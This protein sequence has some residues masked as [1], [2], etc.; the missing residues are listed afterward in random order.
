MGIQSMIL[1][2]I[3]GVLFL[4]VGSNG[5]CSQGSCL[6]HDI[7]AKDSDC[8]DGLKC[9]SCSSVG[10][11][12]YRCTRFN[13]T[14]PVSK[15]GGLPFNRYSWLTTHNSYAIVGE[16][17]YT[18][19]AR[20]TFYN[21][22]DSVTSQLNNGVRGLMLDMYD[23]ENDIWL[24]HSFG[25][26]CLNITAFMPAINTLKEITAFLAAN[27]SEIIT[28]FIEDY[29]K[30]SKGL[31]KVF[32]TAGLMK[33]WFPVSRMPQNGGDWPTVD[34][35]VAKNQ[36]LIVF[37]S[38]SSKEASEGI[39][40][41]WKYVV[42]NQY[43]DAGL[44]NGSCTNRAESK[45]LTS[46]SQSLFLE[47]FF[48]TNPS[49]PVACTVNSDRLSNILSVCYENAGKRWANFLAVD[50]YKKSYGGGAFQAVDKLN[51]QLTC[52][53]SDVTECQANGTF[54]VCKTSSNNK[55]NTEGSSTSVTSGQSGTDA[56]AASYVESFIPLTV[57]LFLLHLMHLAYTL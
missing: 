56:S 52:G 7:C 12:N 16:R 27:P 48:P 44:P 17:S 13:V 19:T 40:Y 53:C 3:L 42:E 55:S 38:Q 57:L 37:T 43:G 14:D 31:T 6:V 49:V 4:A 8:E 46:T 24:C 11:M 1:V 26:T 35:M 41:Q 36:R 2:S 32:T 54:G 25:G 23:F 29:V 47:N 9:L 15:V 45:N 50:Y 33:Y 30:S 28:I 10:D 39:A 5:A 22:D 21:Q 20:F 34:D 18:G 51:G